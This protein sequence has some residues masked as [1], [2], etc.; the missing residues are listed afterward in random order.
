MVFYM[1]PKI[2]KKISAPDPNGKH[3]PKDKNYN[4]Q[5]IQ[6]NRP[7]FK[8]PDISWCQNEQRF[9]KVDHCFVL[10]LMLVSAVLPWLSTACSAKTWVP[11]GNS[12]TLKFQGALVAVWIWVPSISKSILVMLNPLSACAWALSTNGV[13]IVLPSTG[14]VM[15][16]LGGFAEATVVL[17]FEAVVPFPLEL[18][19]ELFG[20]PPDAAA[21]PPEQ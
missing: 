9:Q 5:S 14:K 7:K 20:L 10:S 3:K 12:G 6:R 19:L 16:S 18:L 1:L 13:T 8:T 21:V 15:L 2:S 11:G 4:F 17:P